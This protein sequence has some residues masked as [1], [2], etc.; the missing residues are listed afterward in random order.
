MKNHSLLIKYIIAYVTI[1]VCGFLCVTFVSFRIDYTHVS[2]K[3]TDSLY[4]QALTIA[5]KYCTEYIN[6]DNY[7]ATLR[8]LST[9]CTLSKSRI[10]IMDDSNNIVLDTAYSQS[11]PADGIL[12]TITDFDYTSLGSNYFVKSDLYGVLSEESLNVFAPI[13]YSYS[14]RGYVIISLPDSILSEAVY[15]TFNTNYF[16]FFVTMVLA[17]S[18]VMLYIIYVH[19]P[20][21]DIMRATSEYANG[22]LAYKVNIKHQDEIGRLGISLDYMASKLNEMD[23]FQQKFLSNISHDF[24]SP[25]TSIKG[26]LEAISD[27]TIPPEMINKYIDIVIFE[28]DRLTKLTSN[29][30]TLNELD[31]KTVVLDMTIFDIN[32]IIKHT[33]ETFDGKCKK[34]G[35][36]FDITFSEKQIFVK[37]D[38][39]K[40]QQVIYNLIDNAIKFSKDNSYIYVSARKRSEL[41]YISV[42]DTGCGISKENLDK[43]W[44]RFYKIDASRGRDKKGSGLGLSITKEIIQAHN[45]QIDVISTPGVGTEFTFTLHASNEDDEDDLRN[46]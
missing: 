32:S 14:K 10:M 3:Y 41:V 13:T 2:K 24:R 6:A 19:L 43:I 29:I 40:I 20:L 21:N 22:N 17:F 37:A 5:E 25:L 35:I 36:H 27:G 39:S 23:E 42:K 38:V 12:F 33:I 1:F 34:R 45:S 8:E 4:K 11:R 16:T 7:D 30:L 46:S 26:Y 15:T 31:P 44:T 9:V 18:F 28:T